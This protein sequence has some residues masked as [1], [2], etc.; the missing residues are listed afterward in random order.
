MAFVF[1]IQVV[2]L[3][4][5]MFEPFFR[6]SIVGRA[7][8]MGV[9][10]IELHPLRDALLPQERADDR[11]YGGG[12]GMVLRIEPIARILDRLTA[13]APPQERR[14]V[15]V[16]TPAGRRFRQADA[17]RYAG[18][19]RL[20]VVCGRY[21]GIDERLMPLYEAEEV[22]LGDF[23]VT[24]GEIAAVAVVDATVRLLPGAIRPASL[25]E[26]SFNA[27][28]LDAPSYTRPPSFRG[29]DVP[30]VL[31]SGDH[32]RI[33]AWRHRESLER[34]AVRRPDLLPESSGGEHT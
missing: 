5:E 17:R 33:A 6:L 18:L 16:T 22:S 20:I 31:L 8:D 28:V 29:L 32:Q 14:A 34:T 12:P 24:G 15:V 25:E 26:E 13:A 1:T 2:T 11:P 30:E 7:N 27:G 23:I 10:R 3:F 21:E 4:P 9:V 19:D